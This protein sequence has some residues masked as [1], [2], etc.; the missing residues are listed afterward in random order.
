MTQ[1]KTKIIETPKARVLVADMPIRTND[2]STALPGCVTYAYWDNGERKGGSVVIP[3]G[4]WQLL[5]KLSEITEEQWKRIVGSVSILKDKSDERYMNYRFSDEIAYG[6]CFRTA[7]ESGLSLIESEVCLKNP[8]GKKP[9]KCA[10][11]NKTCLEERQLYWIAFG[12]WQAAEDQVFHNPV[13]F[14]EKK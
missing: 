1:I 14:W 6:D 8:H 2:Y 4:N 11:W 5:G 3:P 12:Q 10:N 13:L 9:A 7:T